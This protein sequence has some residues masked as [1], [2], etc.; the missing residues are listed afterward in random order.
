MKLASDCF[1]SEGRRLSSI[2]SSKLLGGIRYSI[3][4]GGRSEEQS[5]HRERRQAEEEVGHWRP[6]VAAGCS[7]DDDTGSRM[8]RPVG[9]EIVGNIRQ[10]SVSEDRSE[11]SAERCDGSPVAKSGVAI[12]YAD[13]FEESRG[14][15]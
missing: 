13:N 4:L 8:E 2:R 12:F 11:S 14:K 3:E 10:V 15:L 5:I 9:C 1:C 7:S 6:G